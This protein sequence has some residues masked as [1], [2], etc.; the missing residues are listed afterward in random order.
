MADLVCK[1]CGEEFDPTYYDEI[2][3][4]EEIAQLVSLSAT[5]VSYI[6]RKVGCTELS[7]WRNGGRRMTSR[8]RMH[9]LDSLAKTVIDYHKYRESIKRLGGK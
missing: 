8:V 3:I 7:R 6:L 5:R 9:S 4:C 2:L 1:F